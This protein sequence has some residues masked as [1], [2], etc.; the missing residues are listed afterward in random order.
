MV[1]AAQYAAWKLDGNLFAEVQ[2][3]DPSYTT[4]G[5]VP[6]LSLMPVQEHSAPAGDIS[7]VMAGLDFTSSGW[8]TSVGV[9]FTKSGPFSLLVLKPTCSVND[10][11]LVDNQCGTT[12]AG[13]TSFPVTSIYQDRCTNGEVYCMYSSTCL[14]EGSVETCPAI[15]ER[16]VTDLPAPAGPDY[17][18]IHKVDLT[19][20]ETGLQLFDL[21]NIYE[22]EPGYVIG[23]TASPTSAM[24]SYV[25]NT[26]DPFEAEYAGAVSVG[27]VLPDGGGSWQNKRHSV[28]VTVAGSL[29][30]NKMS[31]SLDALGNHTIEAVLNGTETHQSYSESTVV[32]VCD[33]I[34][35]LTVTVDKTAVGI[36]GPVSVSAWIASGGNVEYVWDWGDLE[37]TTASRQALTYAD[38][39]VQTH[40]YA[41]AGFMTIIVTASNECGNVTETVSVNVI[42]GE[43]PIQRHHYQITTDSP[44]PHPFPAEVDFTFRFEINNPGGEVLGTNVTVEIST[45]YFENTT[46]D[47][48]DL[49]AHGQSKNILHSVRFMGSHTA[50]VTLSN[51][52][53]TEVFFVQIESQELLSSSSSFVPM[54]VL[55]V[56]SENTL[57]PGHGDNENYFPVEYPVVFVADIVAGSGVNCRIVDFDDASPPSALTP[58]SE[59]IIHKYSSPGRYKVTME[60]SNTVSP[61]LTV[62]KY[63]FLFES[64]SNIDIIDGPKISAGMDKTL[65]LNIDNLGFH[66][67]IIVDWDDAGLLE[68]YGNETTCTSIGGYENVGYAGVFTTEIIH[69]YA[70]AGTKHVIIHAHNLVSSLEEDIFFVV[71]D[72]DCNSPNLYIRD[73][74]R[75]YN[76]PRI[77]YR[78]DFT[79]LRGA[80]YLDCSLANNVKYWML[81][82]YHP[83]NGSVVEGTEVNLTALVPGHPF[84]ISSGANSSEIRIPPYLLPVGFYRVTYTV[85]MNN[86]TQEVERVLAFVHDYMEVREGVILARMIKGPSTFITLGQEQSILL[87][88]QNLSRDL[89]LDPWIDQG[90]EEYRYFCKRFYED[91]P[92]NDNSTIAAGYFVTEDSVNFGGCFDEGAGRLNITAPSYLLEGSRLLVNMTYNILVEVE[93]EG[94]IG[95]ANLTILVVPGSVPQPVVTFDEYAVIEEDGAVSLNPT[96]DLRLDVSCQA[97]C[98]DVSIEWVFQIFNG[99]HYTDVVGWDAY[100]TGNN[101]RQLYLSQDF[102]QDLIPYGSDLRI[103]VNMISSTGEVGVA[104]FDAFVNPPPEGG[105][106]S[107]TPKNITIEEEVILSCIGWSDSH[108][109]SNYA[110]V[111]LAYDQEETETVSE[112]LQLFFGRHTKAHVFPPVGDPSDDYRLQLAGIISDSRGAK[113]TFDIGYIQVYPNS[114]I[115][116]LLNFDENVTHQFESLTAAQDT[117]EINQRILLDGAL[118]NQYRAS[119]IDKMNEGLAKFGIASGDIQEIREGTASS[120]LE[121]PVPTEEISKIQ[122]SRESDRIRSAYLRSRLAKLT[123]QAPVSSVD[124]VIGV[125]SATLTLTHAPEEQSHS[126]L[127]STSNTMLK[128]VD[129]METVSDKETESKVLTAGIRML[130]CIGNMYQGSAQSIDDPMDVID[131]HEQSSDQSYPALTNRI[132]QSSSAAT[133]ASQTETEGKEDLISSKKQMAEKTVS[134][135]DNCLE[136]TIHL[137]SRRKQINEPATGFR[138][139]SLSLTLVRSRGEDLGAGT[140]MEANGRFVLPS[141]CDMVSDAD[142]QASGVDVE[143]PYIPQ[144]LSLPDNPYNF[145][146]TSEKLSKQSNIMSL[147]YKR[148]G[149]SEIIVENSQKP[150]QIFV[151]RPGN[152]VP[153]F[154][155]FNN[156][157]PNNQT[158]MIYH[159]FFVQYNDSSI[160]IQLSPQNMSN[161]YVLYLSWEDYPSP[162]AYDYRFFLPGNETS[163]D[164]VHVDGSPNSTEILAYKIFL[165]NTEVSNKTGKYILGISQVPHDFWG[166]VLPVYSEQVLDWAVGNASINWTE[167]YWLLLTVSGCSFW[168]QEIQA[169]G[170]YGCSVGALTDAYWTQCLCTHLT[171]FASTWI[172]PPA[173]LD[174]GYIFNNLGFVQN[175]TIYIA[176]ISVY[177]ICFFLLIWARRKDKKDVLLLGVTPLMDNVPSHK[178]LYEI[179]VLTGQRQGAGTD[180]KVSFI[181]SGDQDETEIRTFE[182]E[183]RPI[184]R[185]GGIDRFL[186]SV[187]RPLGTLNYMRIWHDNSGRGDKQSWYLKYIAIRDL[188]TKERFYFIVNRWFSVV[189]DDGQVD[190]LVAVA[191]K[192]QMKEF[193]HVFQSHTAKNLNDGHLWI[194]IYGR[195][196]TSRFSRVQRVG[197]CMMALWLE[198]LVN[199]MWYKSI[200]PPHSLTAFNLGPISMSPAQISIGIQSMLI[201]FPVSLLVV[202]MFRKS[203]PRRKRESRI[204]VAKKQQ[205]E[206]YQV[207]NPKR[208]YLS[209]DSKLLQ[210]RR[211]YGQGPAGGTRADPRLVHDDTNL[212][213]AESM[214]HNVG[215]Y[216]SLK[217]EESRASSPVVQQSKKEPFMF[218]WWFVIIAWIVLILTTIAS[219]IFTIFYG[220]QMGDLETREW[221]AS[222]L[223]SF[224]TGVFIAQPIKVVLIA[225]FITFF[226]RS[227]NVDEESDLEVD[228]ELY[229]RSLDKDEEWLHTLPVTNA[230][231]RKIKARPPTP[232]N[233][234]KI[235]ERRL[236]ELQIF[237]VLKDIF[238]YFLFL[239]TL[240]VVSYGNLDTSSYIYKENVERILVGGDSPHA[241][242]KVKTKEGFWNW[243]RF[244]L[245]PSLDATQMYNGLVDNSLK[246]Y[247]ADKT[248]FILGHSILRQ[249]R[250]SSDGCEPHQTFRNI[251]SHCNDQYSF[252][253][254]DEEFYSVSWTPYNKST[255][256]PEYRYTQAEDLDGYPFFGR[257]ALYS[258][259][260]YVAKLRGS[261]FRISNKI[262]RLFQEQWLDIHS[263]ALFV[264][265]SMYNPQVNL[266]AVVNLVLEFL[267]TGGAHPLTR[268]DVVRLITIDTAFGAF[269]VAC[270]VVFF[271]FIL[272]FLVKQIL[273][274]RKQKKEYLKGFWNLCEC[275][276]IGFSIAA[277]VIFFYRLVVTNYLLTRFRE[278]GGSVFIKLQYVA[279]WNE[280]LGYMLG[281]L[282]FIGTLKFLKL[283]KFNRRIGLLSSTI[284]NCS[285]DLLYFAI[286]FSVFFFAFAIA[287][288]LVLNTHVY[289]YSDFIYT[290]ETLISSI[291]G[292]FHFQELLE[293]NRVLGPILFF[294]F[295]GTITFIL[296]N[297]FLTIINEAFSNV[298]RD[299]S[300]QSNDYEVVEFMVYRMKSFFGISSKSNVVSEKDVS[301]E[302]KKKEVDPMDAFPEKVN[303]LLNSISNVYFDEER[304]EDVMKSMG[305]QKKGRTAFISN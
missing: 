47:I 51:L 52:L 266:F 55:P 133:Q 277:C 223:V 19:A 163:L 171:S 157:E 217:E 258:G 66:P 303:Q 123:E 268:I 209:P 257:H 104:Q 226:F 297:M 233:L 93:K 246:G 167:P 81:A 202:Q 151:P 219:T 289:N 189:D 54:Y 287:F 160:A 255:S 286:M 244:V 71:G 63:I 300:K 305:H 291:L 113:A 37:N 159:S 99:T 288:Y 58:S 213:L 109:I 12:C 220:I 211:T 80:T 194:S 1:A 26:N 262:E 207:S 191:G 192:E 166:D 269:Y 283:L 97:A 161:N 45:R 298:K 61:T 50:R 180:S 224:F 121:V 195:P 174:F 116:A 222:E 302:V 221:L 216:H 181:I 138:Y 232:E 44:L 39:D 122:L 67:C 273:Q 42:G 299:I 260:G 186:M 234:E 248:S 251:V 14:P 69:T 135:L 129:T 238:F 265:F 164:L 25:D 140:F 199:I 18:V 148:P 215:Q 205:W 146:E 228:E 170:S 91:W 118:L 77:V 168:V 188:Q 41:A 56:S 49:V 83:S 89:D 101:S 179:T 28:R 293:A 102:Y 65:T 241:F 172:V 155:Y 249:L 126:F 203:R 110:F 276:I 279:Y 32:L 100:A 85:V 9:H 198:M 127:D 114:R 33:R 82:N 6:P 250:V 183:K 23:F 38:P 267:P 141:F 70:E 72:G 259:G 285:T 281:W 282:I 13:D 15:T 7:W 272:F 261:Q 239:F 143:F 212:D 87:R 10:Y 132:D 134:I 115:D 153:S 247:F 125:A 84:Y 75:Y 264:E 230:K 53:S 27:N 200:P 34:Q 59:P 57:V 4:K 162:E 95:T 96:E 290:C 35:N 145:D 3:A 117:F 229:D 253:N 175:M 237:S 5:K 204:K 130:L 79:Y 105:A 275:A 107:V 294:L 197:C 154:T 48:Y 90:L 144:S 36:L 278:T 11:C 190:R 240:M 173:P 187:E 256:F 210:Q 149:G 158:G 271:C 78:G 196:A 136:R 252:I 184:L 88:P 68:Y 242:T 64:I 169:W 20:T 208:P 270:L 296:I 60:F 94:R 165:D 150:I 76:G 274:I 16:Y 92:L 218:P 131:Q 40:S 185:R 112:D 119:S 206:R 236:K 301:E 227:P 124:D 284:K 295:M 43:Q 147:K 235:R 177:T 46:D 201:V 22:M 214:R 245:L 280:L 120:P 98:D 178:Y 292:K 176:T 17:E 103:T 193:A 106:C 156:T 254:E 225:M 8:L 304:F 74:Y 21:G 73:G 243:A 24:V 263:R 31:F 2:T 128:M 30:E 182:D 29:F 62:Q 86:L 108:G 142:C 231:E 152:E 137:L 111:A 139:R